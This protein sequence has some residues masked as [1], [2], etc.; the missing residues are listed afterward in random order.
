MAGRPGQYY[1]IYFGKEQAQQMAQVALQ[2]SVLQAYLDGLKKEIPYR[3]G[4][5][6]KAPAAAPKPKGGSK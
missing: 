4:D 5:A 6:A 1:L 2:E 3:V